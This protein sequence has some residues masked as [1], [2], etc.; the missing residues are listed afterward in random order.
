MCKVTFYTNDD[1]NKGIGGSETSYDGP[2]SKSNL[3]TSIMN[4]Y[5]SL[6]TFDNS[7]LII[8]DNS[9]YT[10]YSHKFYPNSGNS[11]L[12]KLDRGND[13]DWKNQVRSFKL[14]NHLPSS[15][16]LGFNATGFNNCYPDRYS[17]STLSGNAF[18]YKTQDAKYRVYDPQVSYPDDNSMQISVKLDNLNATFDD[19]IYLDIVFD[20]D[21][22]LSKVGY[23]ADFNNMPTI[24]QGWVFTADIIIALLAVE[25]SIATA[26]AGTPA[27]MAAAGTADT[28]ITTCAEVYNVLVNK[29]NQFIDM[30]GG[31]SYFAAMASHVINNICKNVTKS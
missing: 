1:Y 14:F 27:A 11:D 9:D 26:G 30:D 23:S 3:S 7:W 24:P 16:S 6:K 2:I 31:R 20:N 28:I 25:V 21:G 12:G 8:Y 15:W 29:V 17:D 10:G 22:N 19:H 13:G 4:G 5:D 18:G